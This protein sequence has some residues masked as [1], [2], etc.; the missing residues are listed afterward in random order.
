MGLG[1]ERMIEIQKEKFDFH[2]AN[3][4]GITYDELL[5]LE[6]SIEKEESNDGLIY[7]YIIEFDEETP[8]EILNKINNLEEG[9]RVWLAP[10]ELY[11][12]DYYEE[13]YEAITEN[14]R[15]LVKFQEEIFN[16]AQ[17]NE[18][19]LDDKKIEPILKRQIFIGVIGTLETF[20]SDTFTNLTIDK[21]EYFRNFVE[22]YPNYRK[23]KF[24]LR[25]LYMVQERIKEI[26]KKE[27]LD[28]IYH[29]LQKISQMYAST[30]K[31]DFPSIGPIIKSIKIRHDLVHRNGK[32]K[33]GQDVVVEKETIT[34][35]IN[36]V[37]VF[38]IEIATRLNI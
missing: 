32:T 6:Y 29:D 14:K 28:I 23:H 10:W 26:V 1:S 15:F 18:I 12:D 17:L 30:F 24:E 19:E 34:D 9:K 5:E 33:N 13:L 7:N 16:L 37:S 20:L 25:H 2:L 11:Q 38:V 35:L 8:K 36:K 4:L 27:L 22:K 21:D 3:L 31:I